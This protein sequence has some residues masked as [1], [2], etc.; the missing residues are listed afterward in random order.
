MATL[1]DFTRK[2]RGAEERQEKR[3]KRGRRDRGEKK[4]KRGKEWRMTEER[5]GEKSQRRETLF[6]PDKPAAGFKMIAVK[7]T[8]S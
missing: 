8:L 1:Y 3:K 7:I 4:E 2:R 6:S 5:R